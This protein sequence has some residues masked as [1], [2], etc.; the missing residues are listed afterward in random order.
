MMQ[1]Q[2]RDFASQ[3]RKAQEL[4]RG[5]LLRDWDPIGVSEIRE[6][7]D[8]YDAYVADVY[9]LLSRRAPV[10][11]LFEFLWWVETEHMGLTGDRQRTMKI[12]EQLADLVAAG[13]LP[14][15]A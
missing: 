14:G 13:A 11:E 9:R 6:A 8:E 1:E 12:A 7:Q 3:A 10:N 5:V 4:I 2:K 15:T